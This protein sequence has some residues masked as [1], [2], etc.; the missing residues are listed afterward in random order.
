MKI[1]HKKFLHHQEA[2]ISAKIS[3]TEEKPKTGYLFNQFLIWSLIFIVLFI[4]FKFT[5]FTR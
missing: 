2:T 4:V 5:M 3:P 1:F